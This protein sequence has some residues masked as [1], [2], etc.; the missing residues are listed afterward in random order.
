MIL[1]GEIWREAVKGDYV[2]AEDWRKALEALRNADEWQGL[3]VKGSNSIG[4]SNVV[5]EITAA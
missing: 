5:K 3:L 2:Y 1:V 4:L